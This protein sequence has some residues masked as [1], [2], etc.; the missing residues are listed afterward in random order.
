MNT[1]RATRNIGGEGSVSTRSAYQMRISFD[2]LAHEKDH[3]DG[4]RLVGVSKELHEDGHDSRNRIGEPSNQGRVS[5]R[6]ATGAGVT[7][8]RHAPLN[9]LCG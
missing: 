6:R 1:A 7:E 5:R 4:T 9:S 8:H 3:V 2:Y